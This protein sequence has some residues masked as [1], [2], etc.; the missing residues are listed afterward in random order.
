MIIL[1]KHS[2]FVPDP[3][4]GIMVIFSIGVVAAIALL[5][6]ALVAVAWLVNLAMATVA[7]LSSSI[8]SLYG[9]ADPF[10]Q[11]LII[12]CVAYGLYRVVRSVF[13]SLRK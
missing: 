1:E 4:I 11:L 2:K 6:A 10:T 8:A 7:E 5:I 3:R 9:R 13:R 12:C